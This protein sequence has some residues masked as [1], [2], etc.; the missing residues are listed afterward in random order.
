MISERDHQISVDQEI[1]EAEMVMNAMNEATESV[2]IETKG[3]V[4]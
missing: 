4:I 1:I 3:N 2:E